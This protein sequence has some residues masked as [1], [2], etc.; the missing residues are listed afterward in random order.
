M[1]TVSLAHAKSHLS[2]LLDAVVSGDEVLIT[3]HGT[4]VAKI[5]STHPGKPDLSIFDT[6][7]GTL[8][9]KFKFDRE[10]LNERLR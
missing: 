10:A 4:P 8:P 2:A 5:T 6:H 1:Q 7:K 9:K 3:R